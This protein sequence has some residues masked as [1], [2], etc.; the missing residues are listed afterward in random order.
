[1]SQRGEVFRTLQDTVSLLESLYLASY[2]TTVR[3][4]S[5]GHWPA[6]SSYYSP[7]ENGMS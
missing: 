1:M 7:R 4:A 6:M 2:L 3:N 5:P